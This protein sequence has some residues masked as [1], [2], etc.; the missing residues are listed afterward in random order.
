LSSG[1]GT[2]ID[3][4][5][6]WPR[7]RAISAELKQDGDSSITGEE[8]GPCENE[9]A[10]VSSETSMLFQ[11]D[12]DCEIYA[13]MRSLVPTL[14]NNHEKENVVNAAAQLLHSVCRDNDVTK[15]NNQEHTWNRKQQRLSSL[16]V[17]VG[18][19]E[20]KRS[21]K[22][23]LWQELSND[24]VVSC[25]DIT[26]ETD[27]LKDRSCP[28]AMQ[29]SPEDPLISSSDQNAAPL[30][31]HS[32]SQGKEE[33][34]D[35]QVTEADQDADGRFVSSW[36]SLPGYSAFSEAEGDMENSSHYQNWKQ[37]EDYQTAT[38][39]LTKQSSDSSWLRRLSNPPIP[40]PPPLSSTHFTTCPSSTSL[41]THPCP[42]PHH[43]D[44]H[45]SCQAISNCG[46]VYE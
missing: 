46:Q 39:P 13:C 9:A 44:H 4:N 24:R 17:D 8:F 18:A 15:V 21:S 2:S 31:W 33:E 25:E 12:D 6:F 22:S 1:S 32:E 28:E 40:C 42:H 38:W 45:Q 11:G 26:N 10:S 5:E 14:Q 30:S 3:E 27:G 36:Q 19:K 35:S 43:H 23:A 37:I 7:S 41:P 34:T 20:N 29:R 16:N